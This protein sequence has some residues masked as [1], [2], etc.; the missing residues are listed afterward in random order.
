LAR[1]C[2]T[3]A[4][5]PTTPSWRRG[6]QVKGNAAVKSGTAIATFDPN[7]LYGNHTDGRSHAAIYLGQDEVGLNVLDQWASPNIQNVHQRPIRF[8]GGTPV[9]DGNAFYVVL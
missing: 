1:R 7:G 8:G 6:V 5:T 3:A 9:N 2:R 4:S